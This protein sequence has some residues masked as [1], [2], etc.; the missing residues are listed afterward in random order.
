MTKRLFLPLLAALMTVACEKEDSQP[1]FS[2]STSELLLGGNAGAENTFTVTAAGP[3]QTQPQ[4]AEFSFTPLS[5]EA[6][7]TTVTVTAA[8]TNT[9]RERK[10]LGT[11]TLRA[12]DGTRT[13]K[14]MQRPA[15]AP[16]AVFLYMAGTDLLKYFR[17]NITRASTAIGKNVLGDG[18]FLAL[19]QPQER[20]ALALEIRYDAATKAARVDTLRRYADVVT[21]DGA[22]ITRLLN[23]MADL[24]PAA[25][26][27]LIMGSHGSAWIPA[28]YQYL[29]LGAT[30]PVAADY[31]IK[32]GE[33]VTR[34]FGSNG[35]VRTDIP[36][37]AASLQRA[38]V[39]FDYLIFDACFMSSIET[40]YDLRN[41]TDYIVGSPA[42]VM[43]YGFPYDRIVPPL[44]TAAGISD[45]LESVC[46][47][48]YEFY[49][50]DWKT[51]PGNAQSGC[52]ALSV[53][54]ELEGLKEVMKRINAGK[55]KNW[56]A[57]TLQYYEN[58]ST[59]LF[60][61]LRHYVESM[62][63]DP[64]LLAEFRVQFDKA[65]PPAYRLHTPK[66]Y[67]GYGSGAYI[68]VDP[69]HYCGVSVSEPSGKYTSEN[70]STSWYRD[71]H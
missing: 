28:Q 67:S 61:D 7:M 47:N 46:R 30:P 40:L 24:A 38:A 44:F 36:T 49:L 48:F 34:W 3:W 12:A 16:Q 2:V 5:G 18:R 4:E 22:T 63:D 59:H 15:K 14:V 41:S 55:R 65:F 71:T 23:E 26:Y 19:I 37:L 70:R 66:F 25:R 35:G 45:R 13:V 8:G 42:E 43:G 62:C 17:M 56:D 21:T 58:L 10:T 60:Y 11:I 50:N 57:G 69:A 68:T 27:G 39:R 1:S 31:W 53:C 33:L 29:A 52:I 9:G 32:N 64:A 6:G 51:Y 54:S 20:T